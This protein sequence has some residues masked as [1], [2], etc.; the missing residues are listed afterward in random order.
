[1]GV[2]IHF[3]FVI[4]LKSSVNGCSYPLQNVCVDDIVIINHHSLEDLLRYPSCG[5]T[6]KKK[7]KKKKKKNRDD[8]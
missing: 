2:V 6:Q 4:L 8:C 7:K 1:M 3:S 5:G